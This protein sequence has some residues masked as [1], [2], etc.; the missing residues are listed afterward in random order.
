[1]AK[2]INAIK[3][4]MPQIE[5][6]KTIQVDELTRYISRGTNLT[7]GQIKFILDELSDALLF[8]M[9][10]GQPVK[11]EGLGTFTPTIKLSG[12]VTINVRVD[13]E[14]IKSINKPGAFTGRLR[15]QANIGKSSDDLVD[16]WDQLHP[17]DIV[18]D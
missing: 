12:D 4:L 17:E 5:L 7:P 11:L 1:M 13:R 9:S 8:F 14:L 15:N 6:N 16:E 3:A 10:S 18:I 2:R